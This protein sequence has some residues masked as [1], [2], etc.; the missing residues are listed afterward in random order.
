[1]VEQRRQPLLEQRQPMVHA[2]LSPPLTDRLIQRI[3]G[4]L[5]PEQVA[6]GR[7]KALDRVLVE[8]GFG[9]GEQLQRLGGA[10]AALVGGVEPADAFDLV[11]EEIDPQP[12]FLARR[13]QVEDTAAH[14][15]LALIGDGIDA[16]EAVCDEQLGQRIAVDPLAC[17]ERGRKL[18]DTERGQRA[19][20][21]RRDG[22]E[23]QLAAFRR[24]LQ[25][26]QRRQPI[27]ADAHRRTRAVIG[28]AIPSGEAVDDEV[29]S[30][31]GRGVGYRLHRRVVG[32]DIDEPLAAGAR[33]IGEQQRQEA[34]GGSRERQR[35][36]CRPNCGEDVG[37]RNGHGSG[38]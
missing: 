6:I 35:G 23:E 9:G 1:M 5:R 20:G 10:K 38:I 22:G 28:Q 17:G 33:Q 18:A 34:V 12:G 11:A 26:R 30:K 37:G 25:R 31:E 2:R 3:A 16:A 36:R 24:L 15:K 29:G 21:D 19:L 27:G 8:Q 13:E 32:R 14:R 4:R 7:A